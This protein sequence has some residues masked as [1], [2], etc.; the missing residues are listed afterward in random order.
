MAAPTVL[1]ESKVYL[2]QYATALILSGPD[3]NSDVVQLID[4]YSDKPYSILLG[5]A[6]GKVFEGKDNRNVIIFGEK[7]DD[8]VTYFVEIPYTVESSE[9]FL[10]DIRLVYVPYNV[11]D[12]VEPSWLDW[13][14]SWTGIGTNTQNPTSTPGNSGGTPSKTGGTI[15]TKT[16]STGT[17]TTDPEESTTSPEPGKPPTSRIPIP[18]PTPDSS[19]K[20]WVIGGVVAAAA[21][22]II[23]VGFF[24]PDDPKSQNKA[25][26]NQPKSTR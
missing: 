17:G 23:I 12:I 10:P 22:L 24:L 9:G 8:D 7:F 26:K 6:T 15:S 18:A 16:G 11:V 1:P 21:L 3:L 13:L 4:N 2:Q 20:F 25:S 19:T 5:Y 14:P